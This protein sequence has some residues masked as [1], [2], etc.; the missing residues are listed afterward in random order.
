MPKAKA[1]PD[2]IGFAFEA[3]KLA[4]AEAS[5]AGLE[6]R[7]CSMVGTILASD[8]RP[9]EI[10]AAQMSILLGEE[11]SRSMLDAYSSPARED[12]KVPFCRLLA[13]IAVTDRHDLLD[14]IMREIGAGLLVGD[15][16]KTA[17]IGHL[18]QQMKAINEELRKLKGDAPLIR[19]DT[20]RGN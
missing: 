16:I 18:S 12:H 15:E 17:R 5:L 8:S 3:P 4:R 13:L 14:P 19:G 10:I 2:Q 1:Y 9:R 7:I 11:V 20:P 6:K